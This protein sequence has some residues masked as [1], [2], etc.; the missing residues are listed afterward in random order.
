MARI[1]R[2]ITNLCV[3]A[4]KLQK[5]D[6][7]VVA[8]HGMCG[9]MDSGSTKPA[10]H[11][12]LIMGQLMFGLGSV[13]AALGLPACNPFAF[14]LYREVAAGAILM[15]ASHFTNKSGPKTRFHPRL[16][17]LGFCIFGNQAGVITGIKLAGPVSAAVW[18]PSQPIFTA[19]IGMILG[20]CNLILGSFGII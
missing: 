6:E 11:L 1:C 18:Q 9:T 20:S 14:A 8:N 13:I 10:I 17:W 7:I 12:A 3:K 5:V 15:V 4:K 16:V 2:S 19:A